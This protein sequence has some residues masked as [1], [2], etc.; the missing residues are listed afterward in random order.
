[1]MM[2][3]GKMNPPPPFDDEEEKKRV[4]LQLVVEIAPPFLDPFVC[5]ESPPTPSI[6]SLLPLP[7][8]SSSSSKLAYMCLIDWVQYYWYV[9]Q[10]FDDDNQ[11][12]LHNNP[13][14]VFHKDG[15]DLDFDFEHFLKP[16]LNANL[17]TVNG[18]GS[19]IESLQFRHSMVVLLLIIDQGLNARLMMEKGLAIEVERSEDGSFS[20]EDIAKGLKL[21]MVSKEG[22]EMRARL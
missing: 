4:G 13:R 16:I 19:V 11:Q 1:M 3:R 7:P 10:V 12:F 5:T 9:F 2:H 22:D 18:W 14:L 21:A 6:S 20:R 17:H 15:Y 8:S